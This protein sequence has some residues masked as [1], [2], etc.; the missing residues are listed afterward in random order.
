MAGSGPAT[1]SGKIRETKSVVVLRRPEAF[2]PVRRRSS[3]TRRL[4]VACI[5]VLF[6]VASLAATVLSLGAYCLTTHG[7]D[8]RRLSTLPLARPR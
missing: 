7:G 1:R 4:L 8:T 2:V 5:T 3:A 6:L